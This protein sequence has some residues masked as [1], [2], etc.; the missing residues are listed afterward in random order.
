VELKL[1]GPALCFAK[2]VMTKP[3]MTALTKREG[4][5]VALVAEGLKNK[6]I[7]EFLFISPATV[8]HHLS[9]I[10]TKLEVPDRLK[11]IVYAHR[12]G[13]AGG[14]PARVRPDHTSG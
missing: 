6:E 13:L 11:L 9:S 1:A 3:P 4:Q 8:R 14:S 12:N 2:A 7:A 5:V 10:F